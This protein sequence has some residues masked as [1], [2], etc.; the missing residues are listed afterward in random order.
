M[1]VQGGICAHWLF[2]CTL[3][4]GLPNH[5]SKNTVQSNS[6]HCK[7]NECFLKSIVKE[8]PYN[9]LT[10]NFVR[11]PEG[12]TEVL[13]RCYCHYSGNYIQ[14]WSQISN[15][16]ARLGH[17]GI[18]TSTELCRVWFRIHCNTAFKIQMERLFLMRNN[19]CWHLLAAFILKRLWNRPQISKVKLKTKLLSCCHNP[20]VSDC[21]KKGTKTPHTWRNYSCGLEYT[22]SSFLQLNEKQS[23]L[24]KQ[25]SRNSGIQEA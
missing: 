20:C 11:K 4:C 21:G 9:F 13:M 3:S 5:I 10:P 22:W 6:I 23:L 24:K 16:E 1:P 8:F 7:H 17:E 14:I 2:I 18:L 25:S 15:T 12:K 19:N